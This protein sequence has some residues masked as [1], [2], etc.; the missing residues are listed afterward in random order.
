MKQKPD[1]TDESEDDREPT[2]QENI[3]IESSSEEEYEIISKNDIDEEEMITDQIILIW[4]K[5]MKP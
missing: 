3:K 1:T 2:E 4:M 5:K